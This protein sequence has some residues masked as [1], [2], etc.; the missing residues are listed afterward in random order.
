MT[1]NEKLLFSIEAENALVGAMLINSAVLAEI[2][3]QTSDFYIGK[4]R[5]IWGAAS[6]IYK[7]GIAV[8]L[9][10][11]SELLD[12][13]GKLQEV[14]GT[15][16]MVSMIQNTV[17]SMGAERYARIVKD[18]AARRR[19]LKRVSENTVSKVLRAEPSM[20]FARRLTP[21]QVIRQTLVPF[22]PKPGESEADRAARVAGLVEA[23]KKLQTIFGVHYRQIGE[24]GLYE[25]NILPQ[26]EYFVRIPSWATQLKSIRLRK[27][28]TRTCHQLY[29]TNSTRSKLNIS[30]VKA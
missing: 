17:T 28:S 13:Q 5:T 9:V 2:D 23:R 22:A 1:D 20:A 29:R 26:G 12:R 18:Y 30:V 8:D 25:L 10:T 27:T 7:S 4:H 6:A 19:L 21:T 11:L 15:A 3:I 16:S 24:R 14:G